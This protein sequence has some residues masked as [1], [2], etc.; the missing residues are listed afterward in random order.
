MCSS[1]MRNISG[2]LK[3]SKYTM[4]SQLQNSLLSQALVLSSEKRI[5]CAEI[6]MCLKAP[7]IPHCVTLI[8]YF[9]IMLYHFVCISYSFIHFFIWHRILLCTYYVVQALLEIIFDVLHCDPEFL[10]PLPPP[11][12]C[13]KSQV[14][15]FCISTGP[16]LLFCFFSFS[17]S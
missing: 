1:S 17:N 12:K 11:L 8:C 16:N 13:R 2:T 9:V 15:F 3:F 14:H 4:D 5:V 6:T 7:S 10:I